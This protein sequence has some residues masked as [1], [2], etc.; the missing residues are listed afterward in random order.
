MKLEKCWMLLKE[1]NPPSVRMKYWKVFI[2]WL[3]CCTAGN[4]Q[5]TMQI[6]RRRKL[7]AQWLRS[8][9][10]RL[11]KLT[12]QHDFAVCFGFLVGWLNPL[13]MLLCGD[14]CLKIDFVSLVQC[15]GIS[16]ATSCHEHQQDCGTPDLKKTPKA[17]FKVLQGIPTEPA[18]ALLSGI[19]RAEQLL[20]AWTGC[21][22][23]FLGDL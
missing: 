19:K 10:Q 4:F 6:K 23:R 1:K 16:D 12:S 8:T 5:L 11:T 18:S 3:W 2:H 14:K 9:L 15:G 7:T 22:A 13:L 21:L 17:S 20:S